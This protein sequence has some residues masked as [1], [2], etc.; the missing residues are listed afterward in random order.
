MRV[1]HRLKHLHVIVGGT[2]QQPGALP[3]TSAAPL[4]PKASNNSNPYHMVYRQLLKCTWEPAFQRYYR[5]FQRGLLTLNLHPTGFSNHSGIWSCF[6][7]LERLR[8]TVVFWFCPRRLFNQTG[9][10]IKQERIIKITKEL[11]A[12]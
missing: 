8:I 6:D 1:R 7:T 3:V 10:K 4:A 11:C 5:H 12:A 2:D 9:T